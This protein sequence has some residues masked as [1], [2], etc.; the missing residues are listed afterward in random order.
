MAIGVTDLPCKAH[1]FGQS[2][3]IVNF[4]TVAGIHLAMGN[5]Q[6]ESGCVGGIDDQGLGLQ[7][8]IGRRF[9]VELKIQRQRAR[10]LTTAIDCNGS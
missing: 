7:R 1:C 9:E 4:N 3:G 8:K 2:V 6:G 10:A 5:G